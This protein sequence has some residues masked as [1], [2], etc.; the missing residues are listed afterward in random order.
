MKHDN[1]EDSWERE[2]KWHFSSFFLPFSIII[3]TFFFTGSCWMLCMGEFF[4]CNRRCCSEV[5]ESQSNAFLLC[6]A[7]SSQSCILNFAFF[8]SPMFAMLKTKSETR[9][10][11][12]NVEENS[13]LDNESKYEE[14]DLSVERQTENKTVK[15]FCIGSSLLFRKKIFSYSSGL[16]FYFFIKNQ[17]DFIACRN[18]NDEHRNKHNKQTFSMKSKFSIKFRRLSHGLDSVLNQ[19]NL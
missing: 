4:F 17:F 5:F 6:F 7:T 9:R 1:D 8:E 2:N 10:F 18:P 19:I 15:V 14:S 13:S 3:A 16:L 12:Q 11:L